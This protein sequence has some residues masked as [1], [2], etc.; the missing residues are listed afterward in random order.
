MTTC[1]CLPVSSRILFYGNTYIRQSHRSY[2]SRNSEKFHGLFWSFLNKLTN[3]TCWLTYP[4][5]AIILARFKMN[6]LL[7]NAIFSANT[8]LHYHELCSWA[9]HIWG[10][11]RDQH[12]GVQWMNLTGKTVF[13]VMVP[14]LPGKY[15]YLL[16][17]ITCIRSGVLAILFHK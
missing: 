10:N 2:N 5:P 6:Q 14:P 16:F 7:L 3:V 9:S 8:S 13:M 11:C 1:Q 4:V 17:L 12:T 15:K